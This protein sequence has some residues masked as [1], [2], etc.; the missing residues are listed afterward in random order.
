[1]RSQVTTRAAH[2][3]LFHICGPG[4]LNNDTVLAAEL[5]RGRQQRL[6]TAAV[7]ARQ[8]DDYTTTRAAALVLERERSPRARRTPT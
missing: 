1:M 6:D 7:A 4:L 3:S 5:M 8:L 2:S